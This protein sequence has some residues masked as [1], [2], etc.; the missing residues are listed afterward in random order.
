MEQDLKRSDEQH[1]S[2]ALELKMLQAERTDCS[3][4]RCS[5]LAHM[6]FTKHHED[7]TI[8]ILSESY[9]KTIYIMVAFEFANTV[10]NSTGV[11]GAECKITL[12]AFGKRHK[13]LNHYHH[14]TPWMKLPKIHI[15]HGQFWIWIKL[16]QNKRKGGVILQNYHTS[17]IR[18]GKV[19][20]R[21]HHDVQ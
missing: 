2:N 1:F 15:W 11:Q 8:A 5:L 16:D 4:I 10:A 21:P 13:W 12:H 9:P 14:T 6:S 3:W 19:Q 17:I 20:N 18:G 7:I